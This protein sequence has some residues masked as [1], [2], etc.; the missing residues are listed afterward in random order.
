MTV[1]I[2]NLAVTEDFIPHAK[3]KEMPPPRCWYSWEDTLLAQFLVLVAH[4][5]DDGVSSWLRVCCCF[6]KNESGSQKH[7][8]CCLLTSAP[9]FPL[10]P[11]QCSVA[12]QL[13]SSF[14]AVTV[15]DLP[16]H[17][18]E[19]VASATEKLI[20]HGWGC[21]VDALERLP[22]PQARQS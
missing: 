19:P 12:V 20:P 18:P 16:Q 8:R 1:R 3:A 22:R 4:S 9:H 6:S 11:S 21:A 14:L 7:H 2:L 10:C 17:K 15:R 5:D 13:C